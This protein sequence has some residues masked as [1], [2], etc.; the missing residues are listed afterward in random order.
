MSEN[1][2]VKSLSEKIQQAQQSS[3]EQALSTLTQQESDFNTALENVQTDFLKNFKQLITAALS[4]LNSSQPTLTTAAEKVRTLELELATVLDTKLDQ[5]LLKL[6]TEN[7]RHMQQVSIMSESQ[8]IVIVTFGIMLTL[9]LSA[10]LAVVTRLQIWLPFLI[11][12]AAIL[13]IIG[14]TYA[15]MLMQAQKAENN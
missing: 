14:I 8:K 1:L 7:S 5:A 15:L 4:E 9:T 2:H 12:F 10:L 13:L 3:Y 6:Q 11:F